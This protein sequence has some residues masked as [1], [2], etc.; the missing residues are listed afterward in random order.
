MSSDLKEQA[1]KIIA[2]GKIL[3]DPEL[4]RMG[5]E[6]LD[7]YDDESELVAPVPSSTEAKKIITP[8]GTAGKFNMDQFTMSKAGT[9]AV[10]KVGK[11]QSI[12]TGPRENKY[13]DDGSEA[14]DIKTPSVQPTERIRKSIEN[15]KIEQK[16]EVCGKNEKVLPIYAREFYRC[17][18]CLLKG[19]S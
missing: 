5:L 18:S 19:K 17:E 6:M 10:D 4:I 16:C 8:I 12:Y 14:K 2:K 15:T 3:N 1:K 9:N 11:K 7:A 13:I